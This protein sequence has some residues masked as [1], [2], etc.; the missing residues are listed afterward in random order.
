MT[1]RSLP[2][3]SR[4]LA[5]ELHS[6]LVEL[7]PA[8]WRAEVAFACRRRLASL[9]SRAAELLEAATND[10][11]LEAVRSQLNEL[12]R[13]LR[14]RLPGAETVQA[15]AAAAAPPAEEAQREEWLAVRERLMPIYEGLARALK[16]HAIHV[17]SLRPTNYARNVLHVLT[18]LTSITVALLLPSPT[19]ALAV[20]GSLAGTCWVLEITRRIWPGW[21]DKLMATLGVFAHPHEAYRVNSS[22][23]YL[24]GLFALTLT[25]S[26]PLLA[27][28][29]A[30]LGLGDPAAAI[31][32]RRFGRI[33]LIHG[34]SL[35]GT[36]SFVVAGTLGALGVM[37]AVTA[38]PLGSALVIGL[39]AAAAG[40]IAELVSHRIDDNLSVPLAAAAGASLVVS[41]L[42]FVL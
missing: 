19:W 42:G 15:A 27:V 7:D 11:R 14:G 32:G 9:Q 16:A 31:I 40:A 22:T 30:V 37:A 33:K 10:A 35:E 17:P 12:G 29:M 5:V 4:E 28:A 38:L 23:W 39:G 34:R 2:D 20:A 8:R 13:V 6:V 26:M 1:A 3:A 25:G 36:T 21:N 24:T 18:A 41:A